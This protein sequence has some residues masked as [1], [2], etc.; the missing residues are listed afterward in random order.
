MGS[1]YDTNPKSLTRCQQIRAKAN[2]FFFFHYP[3]YLGILL[4]KIYLNVLSQR[5]LNI[6]CLSMGNLKLQDKTELAGSLNFVP[7]RCFIR[8]CFGLEYDTYMSLGS[9]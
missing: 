3:L 1:V 7:Y 2:K 6:E 5:S 8:C 4:F 9:P